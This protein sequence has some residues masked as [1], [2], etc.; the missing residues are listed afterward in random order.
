MHLRISLGDLYTT[1]FVVW[2]QVHDFKIKYVISALLQT[3][4]KLNIFQKVFPDT[5][6]FPIVYTLDLLFITMVMRI[7]IAA[8]TT[9]QQQW[10]LSQE[11]VLVA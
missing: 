8:T 11:A 1:V 4:N 9:N 6:P 2:L 5:V 3:R 7:N 10:G